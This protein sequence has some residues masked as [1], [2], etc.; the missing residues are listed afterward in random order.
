LEII[1]PEPG[2]SDSDLRSW[3]LPFL[4]RILESCWFIRLE[5][6]LFKPRWSSLHLISCIVVGL[7][8][9]TLV[10]VISIVIILGGSLLPLIQILVSIVA[11]FKVRLPTL[12]PWLLRPHRTRMRMLLLIAR[13]RAHCL[14]VLVDVFLRKFAYSLSKFRIVQHH[15]LRE[16]LTPWHGRG[17]R[18]ASLHG[19]TV[20]WDV[21]GVERW[22]SCLLVPCANLIRIWFI[23]VLRKTQ[24]T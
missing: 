19:L 3:G 8:W 17:F 4:R 24:L 16:N 12:P 15:V 2:F 5:F 22:R 21:H 23:F 10:V 18:F 9:D 11:L 7:H 14:T 20:L 1:F 13:I 6:V